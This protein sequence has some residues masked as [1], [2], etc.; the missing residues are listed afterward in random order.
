M[1]ELSLVVACSH[2]GFP[3]APPERWNEGRARRSRR[4]D[5]PFDSLEENI[6]KFQRCMLGFQVL[7]GPPF[8]MWSA[9]P[10]ADYYGG[11]VATKHAAWQPVVERRTS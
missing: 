9:F 2:T 8:V 3:Y 5:V 10:T 11:S 7:K 6:A 4:G 1:A